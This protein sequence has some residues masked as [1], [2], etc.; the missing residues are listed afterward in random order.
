[1]RRR[2]VKGK[3]E[4]RRDEMVEGSVKEEVKRW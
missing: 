1:M 2:K 4:G 3:C